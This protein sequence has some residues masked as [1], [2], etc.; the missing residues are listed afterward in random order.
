VTL[1]ARL[2]IG[3]FLVA[4]AALAGSLL[5]A[6]RRGAYVR[7]KTDAQLVRLL[8][9]A[10]AA[11][12]RL[13]ENNKAPRALVSFISEAWIGR[14]DGT[15]RVTTVVAPADDTLLVPD[16][17][18]TDVSAEPSTHGTLSGE[19]RKVR[20][21][22]GPLAD[23]GRV[24][25]ALP[26]DDG[27]S[28]IAGLRRVS[29][30]LSA[31]IVALLALMVW[32]VVRLGIDPLARMT[33]SARRIAGGD[34]TH[35]VPD[36]SGTN[37]ASVLA[38]SLNHMVDELR[39][40][41]DR[42]RRFIADVSHEL[43]TPLTTLRGY[44]DLYESGVLRGEG[45]LADAMRRI[46]G[47]ADRMER[48]VNDL[49]E[50][51]G[52]EE[53]HLSLAPCNIEGLLEQC[54]SDLRVADPR[55]RVVV[56]VQPCSVMADADLILQAVMA[57]GR[58]ALDHTPADTTIT[59]ACTQLVSRVRIEVSD[60]GPGVAAEHRAHVFERLYR[61]DAG[62]HGSGRHLGIGLSLVASI[63]TAHHGSF[64]LDETPGGGAT[65]WFDLPA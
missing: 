45:E 19:A 38:A 60:D 34:T 22:S 15:G 14:I 50:L 10:R 41:D 2:L 8:P 17:G 3:S 36:I 25:V 11:V 33:E 30:M 18:D 32:W 28:M 46:R 53:A 44:S 1:R 57:M 26:V 37:E 16:F 64:G 24:V 5:V 9:A 6:H 40:A 63:V 39:L 59:I 20:G 7:E 61:A 65:F 23:G 12:K 42:T 13:E 54:A 31:I 21:I 49:I 58:N 35:R 48:I 43:R 62:R 56:R 55:R 27:E 47:E 52:V 4:L 29:Y 51:R